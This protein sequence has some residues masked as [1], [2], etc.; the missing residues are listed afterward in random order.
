MSRS[1]YFNYI[2]E[3]L[4]TLAVR[5]ESRGKLNILDIHIHSENFYMYFFN[6]LYDL[7]LINLNEKLQNVE[8]IDLIDKKNKL[9]I[10]VSATST[11]H[12]I[13]SSLN[14]PII[15]KHSEYTFIFISISKDAKSLR[16]KTF[17]NPYNISFNPKENIYDIIVI[18]KKVLSLD[19]IKQ[20]Q[21][22]NFIQ[23]ELGAEVDIVQ[24][25]SNLA[26]VINILAKEN[27]NSEEEIGKKKSFEIERKISYNDLDSA[28]FIIDDYKI[29]H[30]RVDKK[31]SEFDEFGSNKSKSVLDNIRM[32]YLKLIKKMSDDEL[33]FEIID[34]VVNKIIESANFAQ[35][36]LDELEL[37]VKILVVDAFIRCKIFINPENYDYVTTR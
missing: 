36:P 37:C 35:I 12:K 28:R 27:W 8:S 29:Y 17:K 24:L 11:K 23:K 31:Y 14:K 6:N 18:L 32:E 30:N 16:D 19:I 21:I 1:K 2:E 9:I 13:E 4:N 26:A 33:F 34:N 3:K 22:Y 5:I 10:Q 7:E 15:N 25:D 20:K